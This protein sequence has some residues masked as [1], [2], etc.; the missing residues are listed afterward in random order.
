MKKI[1][2]VV[3][4]SLEPH[5]LEVVLQEAVVRKSGFISGIEVQPEFQKSFI[6]PEDHDLEQRHQSKLSN[7]NPLPSEDSMSRV[8]EF[9][10]R[11]AKE[12]PVTVLKTREHHLP[13]IMPEACNVGGS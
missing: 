6:N 1:T 3:E 9:R 12:T 8:S 13:A 10:V 11:T 7:I 5:H 4:T 2:V